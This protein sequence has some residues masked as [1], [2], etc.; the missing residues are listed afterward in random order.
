MIDWR[1]DGSITFTAGAEIEWAAPTVGDKRLAHNLYGKLATDARD[2]VAAHKDDK[3]FDSAAVTGDLDDLV[4]GWVRA[5]HLNVGTG[6]LPPKVEDWPHW[7]VELRFAGAVL[8]H[9]GT[10][11]FGLRTTD[12]GQTESAP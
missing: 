5:T 2:L 7:L 4:A 12:K 9:W 11:P 10:H 6:Q 8:E 3:E 1:E